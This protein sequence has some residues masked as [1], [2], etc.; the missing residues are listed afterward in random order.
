MFKEII[1][2]SYNILKWFRPSNCIIVAVM[3]NLFQSHCLLRS[4]VDLYSRRVCI[5]VPVSVFISKKSMLNSYDV[6]NEFNSYVYD[7]CLLLKSLFN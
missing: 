4:L 6:I 1:L 7:S 5:I 3:F 2:N